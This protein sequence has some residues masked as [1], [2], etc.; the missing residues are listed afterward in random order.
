MKIKIASRIILR[1]FFQSSNLNP[2]HK[3]PSFP[4]SASLHSQL[5]NILIVIKHFLP[6]VETHTQ[7]L[8][9]ISIHP[10]LI[11]THHSFAMRLFLLTSALLAP[12]HV[13]AMVQFTNNDFKG[14]TTGQ[15]F[16]LTWSGDGTVCASFLYSVLHSHAK[17]AS[18]SLSSHF[19]H[20]K[21]DN[22][23]PNPA[24]DDNPHERPDQGSGQGLH[25]SR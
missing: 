24:S 21:T 16:N 20:A 23:L 12:L 1:S 13:L 8:H 11:I 7:S 25:R 10:T 19:A 14:I 4:Q 9:L 17:F 2:S 3:S 5:K 6:T 22:T 18:L 15:A